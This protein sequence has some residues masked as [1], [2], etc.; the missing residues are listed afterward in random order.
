MGIELHSLVC[1]CAISA[2]AHGDLHFRSQ[3]PYWVTHHYLSFELQ[4]I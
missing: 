2:K 4:E 3:R 1:W